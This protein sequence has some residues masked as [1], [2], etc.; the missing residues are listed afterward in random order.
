MSGLQ[1]DFDFVEKIATQHPLAIRTEARTEDSLR[2]KADEEYLARAD[3]LD[4]QPAIV[5][6]VR[7][8]HTVIRLWML[9]Y[10][11]KGPFHISL[12]QRP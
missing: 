12:R 3:P 8:D 11:A 1:P 4:E 7:L 6:L 10:R 2:I 5:V 9:R